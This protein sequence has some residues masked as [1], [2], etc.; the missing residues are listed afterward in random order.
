MDQQWSI[1]TRPARPPFGQALKPTYSL[2]KTRPFHFAYGAAPGLLTELP[3]G[4]L[5]GNCYAS[6]SDTIL[7]SIGSGDFW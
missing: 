4:Q 2:R 7:V 5:R 6:V 3:E 1:L